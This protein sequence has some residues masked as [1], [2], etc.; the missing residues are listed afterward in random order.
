MPDAT[1][2]TPST[3]RRG[4]ATRRGLLPLTLTAGLVLA[5][6]GDNGGGGDA[7]GE[8][9][10]DPA[11]ELLAANIN[12]AEVPTIRCG[13][14]PLEDNERLAEANISI[15]NSIAAEMGNEGQLLQQGSS[16][17]ID[18]V[19]GVASI[20]ASTFDQPRMEMFEAYYLYDDVDDLERVRELD[21]TQE[22]FEEF[23]EE[24]NLRVVGSTPW[25]YGERHIFGTKEVKTPEDLAGFRL[26]VPETPLSIASA[27]AMGANPTPVAYAEVYVALQQGI[28]DGSEAPIAI[29]SGESF[30]EPISH[31]N[32][33]NHLITGIHP[34][35]NTDT[36]ESLTEN[37]QEA[38]TE[39]IDEGAQMVRDCVEED[40]AAAL[41]RWEEEGTVTVVEDVDVD[42]FRE[43]LQEE[44]SDGY[45]WSEDYQALLEEMRQ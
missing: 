22:I 39:A 5:A 26:R 9:G 40:E 3:M 2:K 17:E 6:C 45:V 10:D 8:D 7:A 41:E 25:L 35:I 38:L 24:T 30:D 1:T 44:Y 43:L 4:V 12:S 33:T 31:V 15:R 36:W 32:L 42:A 18:L 20:M 34:F 29:I 27:T 21:V 16:G 28:V 19:S 11:V 23:E 13:W 14:L 37:Q